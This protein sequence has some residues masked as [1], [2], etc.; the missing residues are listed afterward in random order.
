MELTEKIF[1]LSK[2]NWKEKLI[3]ASFILISV[4]NQMI[5][6]YTFGLTSGFSAMLVSIVLVFGV[7]V[8]RREK[9]MIEYEASVNEDFTGSVKIETTEPRDKV[10]IDAGS[11][12]VTTLYARVRAFKVTGK[13]GTREYTDWSSTSVNIET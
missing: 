8:A 7:V 1:F 6:G 4:G 3:I 5:T 9:T 12:K 10:Y 2:K 11:E 13:K